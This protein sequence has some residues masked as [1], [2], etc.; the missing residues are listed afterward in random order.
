MHDYMDISLSN[1]SCEY[2]FFYEIYYKR[3]DSIILPYHVFGVHL[4]LT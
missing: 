1:G 4:L 3:D 2:T